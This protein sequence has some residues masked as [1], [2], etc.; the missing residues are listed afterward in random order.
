MIP[1]FTNG[2]LP[3]GIHLADW[4][5][6]TTRYGT[7]RHRKV[8]IAGLARALICL[9]AAGCTRVYVDGSFVTDKQTPGDYD[10]AWELRGVDENLLRSLDPVFYDF[11]WKCAGQKAK[12][13]G[14][15]FPSSYE[16]K[17][18]GDTFLQFFQQDSHTG[19]VKGIVALD[20]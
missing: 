18:T 12:Y 7:T 10:V 3:P 4:T 20:I 16:E 6:F 19:D 11:S 17:N 2:N 5:E 13:H 15:F 9:Q 8:L 14:E 1:P